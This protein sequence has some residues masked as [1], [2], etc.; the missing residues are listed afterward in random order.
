MLSVCVLEKIWDSMWYYVNLIVVIS[1]LCLI[2][3]GI[4]VKING[5]DIDFCSF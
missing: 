5:S 4:L 1:D 3:I 2:W